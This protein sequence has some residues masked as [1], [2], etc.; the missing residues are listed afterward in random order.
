M[1]M[2]KLDLN[3]LPRHVGIIMDG[4]GRWATGKGLIRTSGHKAGATTLKNIFKTCVNLKIPVLTIYAFSTENWKRPKTEVT[5]L[6][7]LFSSFLAAQID[8]LCENNVRLKFIGKIDEL[9]AKLVK[10]FRRAEEITRNNTGIQFN[11]A[12]NYGGRDEIITAVKNI[13]LRR[14]RRDYHGCKKY[15]AAGEERLAQRRA[16]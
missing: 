7:S 8:E 4:N 10:E 2:D 6:M 14:T 13:K 1:L 3:K 5:F 15:S 16:D 9:P 12:V 11:V